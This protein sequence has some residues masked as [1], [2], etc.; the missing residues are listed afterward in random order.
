MIVRGYRTI[1]SKALVVLPPSFPIYRYGRLGQH[2]TKKKIGK[3]WLRCRSSKNG[4]NSGMIN[5]RV[6]QIKTLVS[7]NP[8]L[9]RPPST[10]LSEDMDA[11]RRSFTSS[12][13]QRRICTLTREGSIL[14]SIFPAYATGSQGVAQEL[15][16][17]A[18]E[19][20]D[21]SL[22]RVL[23]VYESSIQEG[24]DFSRK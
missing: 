9:H 1:S 6:D 21:A 2:S 14:R 20:I 17:L 15:V 7:K 19:N 23:A 11:S 5:R 13:L 18:P 22:N 10:I 8:W 16:E 24:V 12:E 4:K 3:C